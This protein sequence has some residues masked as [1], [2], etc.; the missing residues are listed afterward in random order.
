MEWHRKPEDI[1][2]CNSCRVLGELA[3]QLGLDT[4]L[5][6]C[7]WA[8]TMQTE[9]KD[10]AVEVRSACGKDFVPTELSRAKNLSVMAANT[11]GEA[12]DKALGLGEALG[13]DQTRV[14]RLLAVLAD[15]RLLVAGPEE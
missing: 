14:Q 10:G 4:E 15:R 8:V 1:P 6:V 9:D 12:R 3:R 2:L 5:S 11:A 13:E 7:D